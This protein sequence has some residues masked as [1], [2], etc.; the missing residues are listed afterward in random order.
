MVYLRIKKVKSDQYLYLVQSKW[1]SEKNTSKQ[2]IIKYLG[3]A[4][5]VNK[6]DIPPEYRND[7]KILS[8]LSKTNPYDIKKREVALKKAKT[9]LHNKLVSGEFQ[10]A[11]KIHD[12]YLTL[13]DSINFL[14]KILTPVMY[15]IGDD[16]E[17]NKISVATEH[18]ATNIAQSIVKI[19]LD[20]IAVNCTKNK[21]LLCV[22]TGEEHHL[23]CDI[24]E[25]YLVSKG[26]RVKNISASAPTESI[27]NFIKNYKPDIIFVSITLDDC[28]KPGQRLVKKIK[29][30]FNVPTYVG[31]LALKNNISHNFECNTIYDSSLD[32]IQKILKS[33]KH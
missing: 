32:D 9:Q 22:P 31:G 3:K 16:W 20:R 6:E 13:F 19:I 29:E 27:L 14:D 21:I 15:K 24:I 10:E 25:T 4:T 12:D 23:G 33:K 26:Y 17:S 11:L 2:E 5:T 8:V 28:I 30:N 18:V 7:P 1:D